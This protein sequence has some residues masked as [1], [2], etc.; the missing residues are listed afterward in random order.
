MDISSFKTLRSAVLGLARENSAIEKDNKEIAISTCLQQS[1]QVTISEGPPGD[2]DL[3]TIA[4]RVIASPERSTLNSTNMFIAIYKF[5][6]A[7]YSR[8]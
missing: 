6:F 8:L 3:T 5:I 2:D 1:L 4:S 7:M